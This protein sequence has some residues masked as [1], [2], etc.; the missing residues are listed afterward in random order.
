M[1]YDQLV[2]SLGRRALYN[3]LVMPAAAGSEI[4]DTVRGSARMAKSLCADLVR[5]SSNPGALGGWQ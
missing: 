1:G 4:E 2:P 5:R 3:F